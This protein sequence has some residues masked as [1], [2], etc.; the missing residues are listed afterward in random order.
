V[1][2]YNRDKWNKVLSSFRDASFYQTYSF[3]K[4]SIGGSNAET[5]IVKVNGKI[6]A[7]AQVRIK[8]LPILKVG[9]AYIR[10]GPMWQRENEESNL[11]DFETAVQ[12]LL[13]EYVIKRKLLLKIKPNIISRASDKYMEIFKKYGFI[14]DNSGNNSTLLLDLSMSEQELKKRFKKYWRHYLNRAEKKDFIITSSSSI[15][16]FEI[17]LNIYNSMLQSKHFEENVDV[18]NF[19]RIQNELADELKMRIFI[20]YYQD[21]PISSV[22]G[23]AIGETG[24]GLFAA[25]NELGRDLGASYLL[26]WERIKWL[27]SV[28]CKY[29]DLGGI[30]KINN[31]GVYHFK[32][33]INADEVE[34]IGEFVGIKNP[35]NKL[36]FA[37]SKIFK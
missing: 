33:G 1:L 21:Q 28:G 34:Y 20:C 8:I 24:I 18:N 4:F 6:I 3:T 5:F 36:I 11:D 31:P 13:N 25:T 16:D 22:V 30:D 9:I 15:K 32:S 23:S 12:F 35:I 29:F 37:L 17:F 26:H 19:R 10:F 7:A 2:K 14:H 27:K